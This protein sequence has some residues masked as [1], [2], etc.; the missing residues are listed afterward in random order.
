MY[1]ETVVGKKISSIFTIVILLS[2]SIVVSD[3]IINIQ[4]GQHKIGVYLTLLLSCLMLLLVIVQINKCSV[5]YKYSIIAD[6]LI[7]CK[8][9]G[10]K[11]EVMEN[12]KIKDI[13]SIE[14][15]GKFTSKVKTMFCK[16]YGYLEIADNLYVCKYNSSDKKGRFYFEPSCKLIDK[17]DKLKD[18]K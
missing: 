9:K 14:K 8:L 5:K 1:K 2:V 11:Q 6:E 12:I 3:I 17:I 18:H 13:E 7:I 16:K 4:I 10:S 15:L